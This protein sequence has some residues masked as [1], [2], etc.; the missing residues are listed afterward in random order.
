MR[1]YFNLYPDHYSPAFAF[2]VLSYPHYQQCSLRF[3][4][5][6]AAIRAY[7]VPN[8]L[9]DWVRVCLFTDGR[10]D[11]VSQAFSE[12]TGHTPF[13][14]CLS[15][16]LACSMVTIF[17]SSS[18]QLPLPAS[19]APCPLTAGSFR[20]SPH[21]EVTSNLEGTLSGRLHTAPLPVLH[22]PVGYCWSHNRFTIRANSSAPTEQ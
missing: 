4:C 12:I 17:I 6:R 18:L 22:A 11:D 8:L 21:D 15:A 5:P 3:T 9:Q 7:H 1:R 19:L 13:G 10:D 2:S 14:S 20:S 16:A